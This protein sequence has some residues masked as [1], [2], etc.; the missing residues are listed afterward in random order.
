M[1]YFAGSTVNLPAVLIANGLGAWLMAILLLDKHR[2]IQLARQELRP[3]RSM[4]S[5]CLSLCLLETLGFLLDGRNFPGARPL[6]LVLNS[7]LFILDSI[8]A[9]LWVYYIAHKLFPGHRYLRH[10]HT[11]GALPALL[12]CVLSALNPFTEVFFVISPENVYQRTPPVFLVYFI[13]YLYLVS[14]AVVT[15]IYRRKVDRSHIVPVGTFLLPVFLG[16][17]LQFLFYGIALI[18]PSVAVG[19]TALHTTLLNEESDRDALTG[20]Y[21]RNYLIR[22]WDYA[23][24]RTRQG[25][26]LTGMLLDINH[27][28]LVN[29]RYGHSTGDSVLYHVGCILRKAAGPHDIVTR[30][31]GDEFV[32]LT[33]NSSPDRLRSTRERILAG[34]AEYNA[35]GKPPCPISLSMGTAVLEDTNLNELFNRMD[36]AMYEDKRQ[37]YDQ[38]ADGAG[39]PQPPRKE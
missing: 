27:F 4:C 3:F 39:T 15:I 30:Y 12:V 5:L 1:M 35:S 38:Q 13:T 11:W 36:R 8:F 28:K 16:S 23:A 24:Q 34:L 37:Y 21:N 9:Y 17:I 7:L 29:D 22:Y 25:H 31:G 33:E 19:L 6:C 20:V 18:W 2:R 26:K 14:G 32:I 10:L